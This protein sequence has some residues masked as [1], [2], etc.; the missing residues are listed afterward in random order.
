M[1]PK[2]YIYIHTS[3]SQ[4]ARACT[5]LLKAADFIKI[6]TY[7]CTFNFILEKKKYHK[8]I[9]DRTHFSILYILSINILKDM[10]NKSI[11]ENG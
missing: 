2:N 11:S 10:Y 8:S 6:S 5:T 4:S 3:I 9:M 7:I 1:K